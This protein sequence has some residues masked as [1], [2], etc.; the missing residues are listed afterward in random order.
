[1]RL[2][3][4]ALAVIAC[5]VATLAFSPPSVDP[6][7][8]SFTTIQG[9]AG[10]I[11]H[12]E[13]DSFPPSLSQIKGPLHL[14][15]GLRG[16]NEQ[17][18]L[19]KDPVDR[20]S[21]ILRSLYPKH[22]YA[23]SNDKH[24]SFVSVPLPKQAFSGPVSRYIRLEY[25]ML[26]EPGFNWVRGGKL[27]GILVGSEQ[28]CNAECSGGGSAENC[29]STRMMWRSG[30]EGELYLYAAKSVYFPN[31]A[32][33]SCS[34]SFDK[35]SPEA[36]F[37]L[38]QKRIN[39]FEIPEDSENFHGANGLERRSKDDS[40][41]DGMKVKISSGAH[42][43]CNPG[44]GISIGRGGSFRFKSGKWHNVTQIVRVNSKGHSVRDGYLAVYLDNKPV[45]QAEKLVLLKRGYDPSKA[46]GAHRVKFMF[47]SFFGGSDKS[48]QT[49]TDQWIGWKGFKMTSSEEEPSFQTR[50]MR[51]LVPWLTEEPSGE[52]DEETEEIEADNSLDANSADNI[53]TEVTKA[54]DGENS[55]HRSSVSND[56]ENSIEVIEETDPVAIIRTEDSQ[57][58]LITSS[59]EGERNFTPESSFMEESVA[60]SVAD[61]YEDLVDIARRM[62]REES[63]VSG[64]ESDAGADRKESRRSSRKRDSR[65]STPVRTTRRSTRN[66][67]SKLE[68]EIIIKEET[69]T[70]TTTQENIVL[71]ELQ[72][73][74]SEIT[75]EPPQET[76]ETVS[77]SGKRKKKSKRGSKHK[78]SDV[79]ELEQELFQTDARIADKIQKSQDLIDESEKLL[80]QSELLDEQAEQVLEDSQD[81]FTSKTGDDEE[82]SAQHEDD[83]DQTFHSV[84]QFDPVDATEEI[85]EE[86]ES[87]YPILDEDTKFYPD[88]EED[89]QENADTVKYYPSESPAA[90]GPIDNDMEDDVQSQPQQVDQQE[91]EIE[92]EQETDE[93]VPQEQV[94]VAFE[95]PSRNPSPPAATLSSASPLMDGEEVAF[96]PMV[97]SRSPTPP[98]ASLISPSIDRIEDCLPIVT[99]KVEQ[100][101][102]KSSI[103]DAL[104]MSNLEFLAEFFKEQKGRALTRA[105]A[106]HCQ[107]LIE[108]AVRPFG[109]STKRL[110]TSDA[111][112]FSERPGAVPD[113]ASP[114]TTHTALVLDQINKQ[115]PVTAPIVNVAGRISKR[116]A[117]F[118]IKRHAISDL[119]HEGKKE[120]ANRPSLP[121]LDEYLEI[122]KYEGVDWDDL[123]NQVKVKRLLEWKGTEAPEVLKRRKIE[124]RRL[125]KEKNAKVWGREKKDES[126][127]KGASALKRTATSSGIL[128]DDDDEVEPLQHKKSSAALAATAVAATTA[129]VFKETKTADTP[130][131]STIAQKLLDIVGKGSKTIENVSE[132]ATE[133][134]VIKAVDTISKAAEKVPDAPTVAAIASPFNFGFASTTK[135][136]APEASKPAFSLGLPNASAATAEPS[137]VSTA[138][139]DLEASTSASIFAIPATVTPLPISAS[140][141]PAPKPLFGS[142]SSTPVPA[143]AAPSTGFS[144]STPTSDTKVAPKSQFSFGISADT[145]SASSNSATTAPS[146]SFGSISTKDPAT[147]TLTTS[148][149]TTKSTASPFGAAPSFSLGATKSPS[150]ENSTT[151]P[152]GSSSTSGFAF[153]V[154]KSP[155]AEKKSTPSPFGATAS[156]FSFGAPKSPIAEKSTAP[157]FA[158]ASAS[159]AGF[160]FGGPKSPTNA[161]SATPTFGGASGFSFGV[162]KSPTA[163]K[164]TTTTTT[165]STFSSSSFSSFSSANAASKPTTTSTSFNFGVT[166]GAP[167][168]GAFGGAAAAAASTFAPIKFGGST[169][170]AS[171]NPFAAITSMGL[172]PGKE[173]EEPEVILLSDE[174]NGDDD[175]DED[176]DEDY[177]EDED[178]YDDDQHE[179]ASSYGGEGDEYSQEDSYGGEEDDYGDENDDAD[180]SEDIQEVDSKAKA[181]Q[182]ASKPGGMFNFAPSATPFGQ[183]FSSSSTTTSSFNRSAPKSPEFDFT[184]GSSSRNTMT[185]TTF[186]STSGGFGGFSGFGA[187]S[188]STSQSSA[189][190]NSRFSSDGGDIS[191]LEMSPILTYRA[192]SVDSNEGEI[193]PLS[194]PV[195]G[196][197]H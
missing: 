195:L 171:T 21:R 60:G 35:R 74:P 190:N 27:P 58:T 98:P 139:S 150:A 164:T 73:E 138:K 25:Q 123:P 17:F 36:L 131:V 143:P 183:A 101:K 56:Q 18:D 184:F 107:Q 168:A 52:K 7:G 33:D 175:E 14:S 169:G 192:G 122:K 45:I 70:T 158:A 146:F 80:H 19:A 77:K 126:P 55:S 41:L 102:P 49:P 89:D 106:D 144:F 50:M 64:L 112:S 67:A 22:S 47:S 177:A 94:S 93:V 156:G 115:E 96:S 172:K 160:S 162:P 9:K 128:S 120:T 10:R 66:Q 30:G 61:A 90:T 153:G 24:S 137:K 42:N 187:N 79:E 87:L 113:H 155:T 57:A 46:D 145:S 114:I 178:Q 82:E 163:E 2:H 91:Q 193:S 141:P 148:S 111:S 78:A 28:G 194:S 104:P 159:G 157:P 63:L 100:V 59:Q 147:T 149:T 6:T 5:L 16:R 165:T 75:T 68:E 182:A 134:S 12:W 176:Q 167:A 39:K 124:E 125:M 152:F 11:Y 43:K 53:H 20:S 1:M 166:P 86:Q 129:A 15:E 116:A 151:S 3:T 13:V 84:K 76:Q 51:F 197:Q 186:G 110:S 174:E 38:E 8:R 97:L 179:G 191:D 180:E 62:E 92:E 71:N 69:I 34:R 132:E 105:Q 118:E 133:T 65:Q 40:C 88:D 121:P 83:E 136:S 29:F 154:P 4:L 99:P 109:A 196:P 130:K 48:Y 31:E 185:T 189:A 173:E 127:I 37:K 81:Q 72:D 161:K 32:P 181:V 135:D 103:E 95:P 108:E 54:V 23:R 170:S 188:F 26:F 117:P 142:L 44:Y 140:T 85:G 119:Y